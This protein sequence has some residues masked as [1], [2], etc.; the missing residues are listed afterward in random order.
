MSH[1][2][3]VLHASESLTW[4]HNQSRGLHSVHG[5]AVWTIVSDYPA[6][7]AENL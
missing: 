7:P 2:S 4:S 6:N 1:V 5:V 3:I